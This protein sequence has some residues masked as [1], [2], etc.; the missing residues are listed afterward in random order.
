MMSIVKVKKNRKGSSHFGTFWPIAGEYHPFSIVKHPL[1]PRFSR[2]STH[3]GTHLE[4]EQLWGLT[5]D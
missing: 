1:E 2:G 3:I 4:G 5:V